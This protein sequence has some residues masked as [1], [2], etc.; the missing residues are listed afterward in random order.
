MLSVVLVNVIKGALALNASLGLLQAADITFSKEIA[1]IFY[2]R[3]ATCHH[4]NDIAPMSLITYRDARPWA[5]ARASLSI[6][7]SICGRDIFFPS[8]NA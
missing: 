3:C 4:P 6:S 7:S 8:L 2:Q 1:P 5:N